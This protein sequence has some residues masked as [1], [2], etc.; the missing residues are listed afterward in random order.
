M[1]GVLAS[2]NGC[3]LA[4]ARSVAASAAAAALA[5]SL[6]ALS[7]DPAAAR[8]VVLHLRSLGPEAFLGSVCVRRSR[9]YDRIYGESDGVFIAMNSL[10]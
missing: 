8:R 10:T 6:R 4:K 2:S 3:Q 7:F 9:R 5:V 1:D